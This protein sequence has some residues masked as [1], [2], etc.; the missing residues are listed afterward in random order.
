MHAKIHESQDIPLALV[1]MHEM[2]KQNYFVSLSLCIYQTSGL[3]GLECLGET[4]NEKRDLKIFVSLLHL[5]PLTLYF[6]LLA[7][8]VS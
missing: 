6:C 1:M 2:M 4:L 5:I 8:S 7:R 3:N